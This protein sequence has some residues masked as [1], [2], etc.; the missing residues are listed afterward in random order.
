VIDGILDSNVVIDLLREVSETVDWYE[1]LGKQQFAIVP[2]VWM[3]VVQGAWNKLEQ[4]RTVRFLSRF[5]IEHPTEADN[6][7]AM[8]Q[9]AS[10]NLSHHIQYQDVMIA[11]VAARLNVP[12]YTFNDR[13]FT[14][15][16]NVNVQ[17][18]Y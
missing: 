2:I 1:H 15:F 17:R 16:P 4:Q 13:H 11:S 6:V 8:E 7:W 12:L 18:P 5:Q 10:F 3:E 14:P 9:F